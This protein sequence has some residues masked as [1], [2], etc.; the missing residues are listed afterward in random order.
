MTE[1]GISTIPTAIRTAL[2]LDQLGDIP[3]RPGLAGD[4]QA[5]I[6]IVG[7]GFSGLWTALYLTRL[8]P[9]LRIVVVE[10][11]FC[12][13]GASGRNGGWAVGELAGPFNAYARRSSPDEALR[14]ARAVFDAVD[15]IG[16]M[17]DEYGIDCDY[18]RGGW[19][20]VARTG[21]QARR[22]RAEIDH[23]RALGFT[24]DEVRLL[25]PDEARGH[26]NATG[27]RSGIFFDACAALHPA[28][29][30]RGLAR[31]VEGAGVTIAEGTE[32][33]AIGQG[34]VETTAG[35][36]RAEVVIRAT[37]A[38]TRDLA[39]MRRDL[40]PVYSLMVATEPL[41]AS[42]FDEIGLADRPTFSDDRFM[43]IYG[44]RTADDRLAFGGRGVPYLFGSRIDRRAELH[45]PSHERLRTTLIELLP[46]LGDATFTH[47]W[48]G[49]LGIPRDWVPGLRFDRRTGLGVLGGYVGE[50]V[51][52][53]NLA[54]RTMADLVVGRDTDRTSLPWVGVRARRWEPE[55]LRWLGV[56]ASRRLLASADDREER[57]DREA[58]WSFRI[59]RLLRGA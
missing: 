30:A 56:R 57:T 18:R 3:R 14:Q 45:L 19:I 46:V 59:S 11:H 44:Q 10:K 21:P 24:E 32:V 48:G 16:R 23:D 37:E 22:Q 8:D 26:L 42:V 31:V 43:V 50:G 52:A 17:A 15:E 7:G 33:T 35:T 28:R 51:A 40:L 34:R 12:G 25:G 54:G 53:A 4:D 1:V 29:L 2:W 49:V 38:Y 20:R 41:P 47:R 13:H 6:V 55:P 58:R 5:D 36:I 9:S 39:G 27:V